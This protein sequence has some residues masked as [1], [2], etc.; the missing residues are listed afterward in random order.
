[1]DKK[2]ILSEHYLSNII[3]VILPS[4][5]LIKLSSDDQEILGAVG[6]IESEVKNLSK[7]INENVIY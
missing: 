4:L 5:D 3:G 6:I 1:M 7:V 2:I